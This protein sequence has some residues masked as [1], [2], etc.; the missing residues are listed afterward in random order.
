[1]LFSSCQ[2][3]TNCSG[4][5]YDKNGSTIANATIQLYILIGSG[6]F[7]Y[8]NTTRTDENGNY[9]F[10]F[11]RKKF[12]KYYLGCS[13]KS[14]G[15]PAYKFVSAQYIKDKSENQINFHLVK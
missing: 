6:D 14:A 12:K 9:F 13:F 11:K 4:T 15:Y 1:M 7:K 10:S 8:L 3:T 5:V 2:K